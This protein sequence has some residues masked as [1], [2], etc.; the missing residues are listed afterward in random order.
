MGDVMNSVAHKVKTILDANYKVLFYSGQLDI[1]VAYP[2]T[3]NFL[4]NL[5]WS[6]QAE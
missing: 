4:K 2:L 6:G 3:L 1:I 5:E